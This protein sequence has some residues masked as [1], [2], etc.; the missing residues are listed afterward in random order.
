MS[1][2]G[3]SGSSS[4]NQSTGYLTPIHLTSFFSWWNLC[5]YFFKIIR[6]R[7]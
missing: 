4:K 2:K 6:C 1:V 3:K 7:V 5:V